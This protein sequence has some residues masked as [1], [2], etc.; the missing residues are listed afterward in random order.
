MKTHPAT[1]ACVALLSAGLL[2]WQGVAHAEDKAAPTATEKKPPQVRTYSSVTVVTDPAHAPPLPVRPR[3][4]GTPKPERSV[5]EARRGEEGLR[6]SVQ[7]LRGEIQELRKEMLQERRERRDEKSPAGDTASPGPPTPERKG[8]SQ[9]EG[10]RSPQEKRD[11]QP[12]AQD[13]PEK[14]PESLR[15][16]EPLRDQVRE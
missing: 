13:R 16:R 14:T 1:R 5:P 10:A 9:A 8:A 3:E 6:E 4:A 2:A 11:R 15:R 12:K 7:K